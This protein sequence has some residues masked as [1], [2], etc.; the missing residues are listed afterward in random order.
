MILLD[1]YRR[2]GQSDTSSS[3]C[4]SE[5]GIR[6]P[7]D[8]MRVYIKQTKLDGAKTGQSEIFKGIRP[9]SLHVH[10]QVEFLQRKGQKMYTLLRN[11]HLKEKLL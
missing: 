2:K 7:Y 8:E 4:V 5:V 6:K 9:V 3:S 10:Q 11:G 1:E